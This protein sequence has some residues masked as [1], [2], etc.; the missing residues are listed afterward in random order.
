M[1]SA[2]SNSAT[3]LTRAYQAALSMKVSRQDYWG[4]LPGCTTR[5]HPGSGNKSVSFALAGGF[6]TVE[7]P[8]KPKEER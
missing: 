8:G 7:P 1:C 6:F 3:P 4:E 5:D 2:G